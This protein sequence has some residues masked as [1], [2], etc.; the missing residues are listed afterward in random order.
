[1]VIKLKEIRERAGLSTRELA[2]ISNSTSA[3]ISRLENGKVNASIY[4]ICRLALALNV[5]LN[6]LIDMKEFAKEYGE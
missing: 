5:D 3:T 6:D 2:A 1:M 4:L